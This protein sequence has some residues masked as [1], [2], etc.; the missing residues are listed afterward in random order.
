MGLMGTGWVTVWV[1]G[2]VLALQWL[3][4]IPRLER[5]PVDLVDL[6]ALILVALI[7]PTVGIIP[8]FWIFRKWVK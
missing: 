3:V 4:F 5:E 2:W 8:F 6:G 7:I 1:I